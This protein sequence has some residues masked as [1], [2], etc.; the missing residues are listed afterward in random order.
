MLWCVVHDVFHNVAQKYDLMNDVMSCGI[1]RLWK[2]YFISKMSPVQGTRLLD[3]AGGTGQCC[4]CTKCTDNL[5]LEMIH[6][7]KS[8][9]VMPNVY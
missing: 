3:V 8:L 5:L 6:S 9:C 1:H 4:V 7:L 2:D